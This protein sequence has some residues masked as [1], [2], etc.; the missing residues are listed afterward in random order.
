MK[1]LILAALT[2]AILSG[3]ATTN[4]NIGSLQFN[5]EAERLPVNYREIALDL[6]E[7]RRT[8]GGQKIQVSAPG[9]TV[10]PTVSDPQ[11]WYVCLS[12]I[13]PNGPAPRTAQIP[14]SAHIE[15]WFRGSEN[16][17]RYDVIVIVQDGGVPIVVE[18]YDARLCRD[19][20]YPTEI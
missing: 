20:P 18:G 5:D 16:R 11:R 19:V 2:A 14:V 1:R 7:N 6:V 12:G 9:L 17:S 13:E 8:I 15:N 3:C 10:G 4:H